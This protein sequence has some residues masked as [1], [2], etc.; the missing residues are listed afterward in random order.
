MS[1]AWHYV[2]LSLAVSP[3]V[4]L[5]NSG[6]AGELGDVPDVVVP[7]CKIDFVQKTLVGSNESGLLQRVTVRRGDRVEA[8]Q[9]LANLADGEL[10]AELE[11]RTAEAKSDVEVR[12]SSIEQ[13]RA[14][15]RL[16]TSSM[17]QRRNASSVEQLELDR[18]DA[19]I[20][21]LAVEQAET[22]RH[23]ARLQQAKVEAMVRARQIVSP[24]AGTVAE[25]LKREGE[26]LQVGEPVLRIVN[27]ELLEVVGRL[28]VGERWK[29]KTGMAVRIH[30]VV[31]GA[32]LPLEDD[33][34]HGK[35]SHLGAEIEASTQTCEVIAEVADPNHSLLAGLEA[36]MEIS[37][38]P[39]MA[40]T[41][42]PRSSAP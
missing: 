4:A 21:G 28:D 37:T 36:T 16:S 10:R 32:S 7:Y 23:L 26:S 40:S 25:V 22:R 1:R 2:I 35:V 20:A 29:V 9:V 42:D 27:T 12:L 34:F 14:A 5:S 17:L 24:H 15:Y 11:L 31:K 33:E 38:N 30:V 41:P 13:K 8:G 19:E 3:L 6:Q 39:R 18:M